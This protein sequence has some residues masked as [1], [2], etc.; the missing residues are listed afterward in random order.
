MSI[1]PVYPCRSIR[2]RQRRTLLRLIPKI[3]AACHHVYSPLIAR[4]R[5]SFTFI[6]RSTAKGGKN[7]GASH[8]A[9]YPLPPQAQKSGHFTC[10]KERTDHLL[11]TPIR[12]VLDLSRRLP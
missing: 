4:T 10:A 1:R 2:N 3:S 6:A 7:I 9:F 12:H 5:T 11:S 8:D